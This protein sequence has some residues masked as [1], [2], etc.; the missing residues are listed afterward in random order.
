MVSTNVPEKVQKN[1]TAMR[2][3]S[4][5]TVYSQTTK[6]YGWS[7]KRLSILLEQDMVFVV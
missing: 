1:K 3:L 2:K 7:F 5:K 6:G 4:K